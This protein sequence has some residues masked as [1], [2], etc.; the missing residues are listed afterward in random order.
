MDNDYYYYT[1]TTTTMTTPTGY[2]T[3]TTS[4]MTKTVTEQLLF[5][6]L[7]DRLPHKPQN[8]VGA[9]TLQHPI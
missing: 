4:L 9:A 6:L 5:S 3:T 8:Q 7:L 1:T 2:C